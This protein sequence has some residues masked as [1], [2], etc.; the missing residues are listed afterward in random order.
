MVV[1]GGGA[2]S[3]E[4]GTHTGGAVSCERGTP[5]PAVAALQGS[6][7]L[8]CVAPEAGLFSLAGVPRSLEPCPPLRPY[9]S[10]YALGHMVVLGGGAVCYERGTTLSGDGVKVDTE[11]VPVFLRMP[12]G[13]T[14]APTHR[15]QGYL[16]HKK[17]PPAWD[18]HRSLGI[19]LLS[20]PHG[21]EL[22][23]SEVPL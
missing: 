11:V 19:G 2:V 6:R 22:L 3:Y 1:L 13:R 8:R 18:H 17:H 10:I 12:Y 16:A 21:R 20:G 5:V 14:H 4:R 15:L 7:W 23:M 9:S